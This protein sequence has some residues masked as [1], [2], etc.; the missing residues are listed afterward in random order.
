MTK[1]LGLVRDFN[2]AWAEELDGLTAGQIRDSVDSVVANR[3]KIAHGES[4][5]ISLGYARQYY[6]G[7]V[8]LID[9]MIEQCGP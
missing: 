1:V 5:G 8:Q 9:L 2:P 3:H 4:V 6:K 7:A